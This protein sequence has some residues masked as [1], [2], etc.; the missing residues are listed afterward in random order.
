[1][2]QG[3]G[4]QTVVQKVGGSNPVFNF[5][6]LNSTNK[7]KPRNGIKRSNRMNSSESQRMGCGGSPLTGIACFKIEI[8]KVDA[9]TAGLRC[10]E[11]RDNY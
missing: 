11:I 10:Y 8:L 4:G 6:F 3:D 7:R 5:G 1:M 2:A 9:V